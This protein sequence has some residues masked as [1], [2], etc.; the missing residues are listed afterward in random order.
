[1]SKTTLLED[2]KPKSVADQ[3]ADRK[4]A[5]KA[6][7]ERFAKEH[8][9]R[10][11]SRDEE[12]DVTPED[13]ISEIPDDPTP[14]EETPTDD[15]TPSDK[16]LPD[17][18]TPDSEGG[19]DD[20]I[21]DDFEEEE[22]EDSAPSKDEDNED[23]DL[24]D[25]NTVVDEGEPSDLSV[26][27]KKSW[28]KRIQEQGSLRKK[29]EA[30]LVEAQG[31][32]E[33][34][35]SENKKLDA[36]NKDIASSSINWD[37]H[38][39]VKPMW[40]KFDDT[41]SNAVIHFSDADQAA[42]FQKDSQATLLKEYYDL[43]ADATT[44]AEKNRIN[45][46]YKN[47]LSERYGIED[48]TPLVNSVREALTQYIDIRDKEDELKKKH[49]EGRLSV[50]VKAYEEGVKPFEELFDDL[51]NVEEE[52]IESNPQHVEAIV[53]SR[54]KNDKEFYSKAEKFK[55]RIKQFVFGLRP[56]AQ[57][58]LDQAEKRAQARG[59]EL[60]EFLTQREENYQKARTKF[61]NDVFFSGMAMDEFGDMRKIYSR[62]LKNKEKRG[63]ARKSI[64]KA[65]VREKDKPKLDEDKPT[66]PK[67]K[68]YVPPTQRRYG[69]M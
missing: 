63:A 39:E 43:T 68:T 22:E 45:I 38:A 53:A 29:A 14:V 23:V 62:Y 31:E 69:K 52:F 2:E 55:D 51:G 17:L 20:D 3:V 24:E 6:K 57:K 9:D 33:R 5:R 37:S 50:G 61:L 48:A 42:A 16:D 47:T 65:K 18:D 67:D 26:D 4:A 36:R 41:I 12:E 32:I 56:L 10:F 8:E 49:E 34:L 19:E 13:T 21:F 27:Q 59:M 54:I 35:V 28:R 64:S 46:E 7:E 1:M 60:Q 58:E 15:P 44:V 40:E 25:D 30:D 66:R 11:V